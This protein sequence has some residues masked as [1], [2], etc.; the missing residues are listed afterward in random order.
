MSACPS[1]VTDLTDAQAFQLLEPLFEATREIFEGAG[2][3]AVRRVRLQVDRKMHDTARH[4]GG[5]RDDGL[6]ILLAPELIELPPENTTAIIAHEF[7]HATDFLYPGE[8]VLG[9]ERVARRRARDSFE[10]EHWAKCVRDWER[11]DDD[12]IEYVADAVAEM[13]TG[14]QIGYTG[15]CRLQTY[16]RGRARPAGLR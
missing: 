16:D 4:F 6:L 9:P 8:F 14:R 13:V 10:A 2:L 11:R 5:T 7:G 15:S 3:K 12:V 1:I